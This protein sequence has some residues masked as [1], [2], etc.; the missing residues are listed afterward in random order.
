MTKYALGLTVHPQDASQTFR[1]KTLN[2]NTIHKNFL[3]LKIKTTFNTCS[4]PTANP[5]Y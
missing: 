4:I 3:L 1:T 2:R 5:C